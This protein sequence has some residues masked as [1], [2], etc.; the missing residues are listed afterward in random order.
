MSITF[1]FYS[2]QEKM[3]QHKEEIVFLREVSSFGQTGF[4]PLVEV[5]FYEWI[6]L[7]EADGYSFFF[8]ENDEQQTPYKVGD[9]AEFDGEQFQL[10]FHLDGYSYGIGD[11]WRGLYWCSADEF[12]KDVPEQ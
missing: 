10:C 1:T 3:P 5:V 12:W 9:V 2:L 4:K 11:G 7:G 8:D 6:G